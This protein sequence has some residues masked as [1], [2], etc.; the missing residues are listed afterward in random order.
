[1][2]TG[3]SCGG[4]TVEMGPPDYSREGAGTA[5]AGATSVQQMALVRANHWRTSAGIAAYNENAMLNTSAT[6]HA[7]F[8]NTTPQA[9]CW[10]GA[11][12]EVS[13]CA[14][15]TG[16]W[17][18]DRMT[19]AGYVWSAAAEDM[20]FLTDPVAAVDGW[21]WTVYHRHP[22]LTNTYVDLGYGQA[23]AHDVMDFGARGGA[24]AA[25][26]SVVVFPVPGQTG[27]PPSFG[28]GESPTPPAPATTHA[29]PSGPVI[30]VSLNAAGT[31]TEHTVMDPSCAPLTTTMSNADGF[32]STDPRFWYFYTDRP[33]VSGQ[34]YT[35]RVS[36][37]VGATSFTRT[38]VFTTM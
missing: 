17:P 12:D 27:V 3:T 9:T 26:P 25:M 10:P 22:F 6:H 19:A 5:A 33:L 23:G 8:T 36:G 24:T 7:D 11:H 38:W 32:G 14:G 30:S 31:V 18:W 29:F 2:P 20:H 35:V 28:G 13:T 34:R 1:M 21:I 37:T 16:H 4:G 15:Y